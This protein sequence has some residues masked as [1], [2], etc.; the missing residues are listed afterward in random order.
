MNL[1]PAPSGIR[2]QK[3]ALVSPLL[4]CFC[5]GAELRM[6][7]TRGLAVGCLF[8]C[9][10]GWRA[11][12]QGS[13]PS[14]PCTWLVGLGADHDRRGHSLILSLSLEH[15]SQ[16]SSTGSSCSWLTSPLGASP[17]APQCAIRPEA[18]ACLP[19]ATP[20]PGPASFAWPSVSETL[21]LLLMFLK[22]MASPEKLGD[23]IMLA[24]HSQI[25]AVAG[26]CHSC[27]LGRGRGLC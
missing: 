27:V 1:I 7:W 18:G 14:L 12:T 17:L 23:G 6:G 10:L 16:L 21:S 8:S 11:D 25:P 15:S 20:G 24:L 19:Q 26:L 4:Y 3:G 9:R 5:G 22:C 13:S 2:P